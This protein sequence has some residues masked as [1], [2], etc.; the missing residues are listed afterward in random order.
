[1]IA[2]GGVFA[3]RPDADAMLAAAVVEAAASGRLVPET[4]V[5]LIDRSYC[6]Y[7]VGLLAAHY[8][9]AAAALARSSLG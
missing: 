9:E 3:G 4:P 1:L 8:P 2:S 5:N 7:A 6:L